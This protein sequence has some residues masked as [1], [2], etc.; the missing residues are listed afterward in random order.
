MP[1]TVLLSPTPYRVER[2]IDW[3]Q[4][5]R[6]GV[7]VF[8]WSVLRDVPSFKSEVSANC[9]SQADAERIAL[10]LNGGAA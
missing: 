9:K 6:K 3:E 4:T 8:V 5:H 2:D 7:E 1:N 10:L